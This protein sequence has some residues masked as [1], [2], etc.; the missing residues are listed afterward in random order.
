MYPK[1]PGLEVFITHWNSDYSKKKNWQKNTLFGGG[2]VWIT[3]V[4]SFRNHVN[5]H[6]FVLYLAMN[7]CDF[8]LA[9]KFLRCLSPAI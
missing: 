4:Y 6:R 1:I 8:F 2:V 3:V 5:V 7:F 9:N